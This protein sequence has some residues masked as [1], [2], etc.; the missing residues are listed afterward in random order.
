MAVWMET[1]FPKVMKLSK[2]IEFK[3]FLS[4]KLRTSLKQFAPFVRR[5]I[6]PLPAEKMQ[7]TPKQDSQIISKI[8]KS[9]VFACKKAT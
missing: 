1:G 4:S 6:L 5:R 3:E 7:K 9:E 8:T 2:E